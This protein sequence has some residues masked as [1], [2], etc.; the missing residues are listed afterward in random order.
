MTPK[1]KTM[2]VR[3]AKLLLIGAVGAALSVGAL[4]ALDAAPAGARTY[5]WGLV[6]ADAAICAY[7]VVGVLFG[8]VELLIPDDADERHWD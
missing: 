2:L 1:V 5:L 6:V 8:L 3:S 7:A 4:V